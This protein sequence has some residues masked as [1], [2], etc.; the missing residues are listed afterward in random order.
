MS[1]FGGFAVF[2][3]GLLDDVFN[4]F[5]GFETPGLIIGLSSGLIIPNFFLTVFYGDFAG[6]F[7]LADASGPPADFNGLFCLIPCADLRRTGS[8]KSFF[9]SGLMVSIL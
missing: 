7:F 2:G 8:S 3:L 4:T 1:K 6:A 5:L 9:L